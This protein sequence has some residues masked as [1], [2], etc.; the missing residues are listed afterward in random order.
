MIIYNHKCNNTAGLSIDIKLKTLTINIICKAY[1]ETQERDLEFLGL[2]S[3]GEGVNLAFL[4]LVLKMLSVR[5][6]K[7]S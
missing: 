1:C 7:K 4:C 6:D 2:K 5:K 3:G